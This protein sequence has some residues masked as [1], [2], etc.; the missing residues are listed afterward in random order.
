MWYHQHKQSILSET[1]FRE[2]GGMNMD[3]VRVGIIGVGNMGSAHAHCIYTGG[4][5][6][7]ELAALCDISPA[8]Q[9]C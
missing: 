9:Y 4:I 6:G 3:K 1:F 7:L 8:R 2:Y 5:E